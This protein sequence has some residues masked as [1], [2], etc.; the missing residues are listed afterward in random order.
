MNI[1]IKT[2]YIGRKWTIKIIINRRNSFKKSPLFSIV[3]RPLCLVRGIYFKLI[4][5]YSIWR[6]YIAWN[7]LQTCIWLVGLMSLTWKRLGLKIVRRE[8][9]HGKR[10]SQG[11]AQLRGTITVLLQQNVNLKVYI[12]LNNGLVTSNL[13]TVKREMRWKMF[14][15]FFILS[16][17]Y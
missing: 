13:F 1:C 12:A 3:W 15:R 8:N 14:T 10:D 17:F 5:L 16:L 11:T 4:I 2:Y 7:I 6:N 9:Y